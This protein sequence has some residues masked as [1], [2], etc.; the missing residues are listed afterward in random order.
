MIRPYLILATVAM[1]AASCL[2][3]GCTYERV[4]RARTPLS[5]IAGAEGGLQIGDRFDGE[6]VPPSLGE[7]PIAQIESDGTVSLRASSGDHLLTHVAGVLETNNDELF[8]EQVLSSVTRQEFLDRG[9]DPA[10]AF[11]L[12]KAREEAFRVLHARMPR[13]EQTPAAIMHK[14]GSQTFRVELTGLAAR[15]LEWRG[16]DM[17]FENGSF[18]LRWFV[19]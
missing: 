3:S 5:G 6:Y 4:V 8:V 9:I 19:G 7:G 14:V 17:V 16:F 18:R 2:T 1:A 13:G 12:V 11:W 10:E 15:G